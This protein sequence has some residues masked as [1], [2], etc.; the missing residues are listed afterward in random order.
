MADPELQKMFMNLR[1]VIM[2]SQGRSQQLTAQIQILQRKAK[3]SELIDKEV[4]GLK[5]DSR[6]YKGVGRMFMLSS[7]TELRETL[8]QDQVK[9]FDNIKQLQ[10]E[11]ETLDRQ[12]K[13]KEAELR[14]IISR[15][16]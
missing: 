15:R 1:E 11:K 14:E 7:K 8:K 5:D 12:V 13:N 4:A 3:H 9:A 2:N 16:K 10:R 6:L